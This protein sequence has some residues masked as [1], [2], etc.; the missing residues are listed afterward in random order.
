M[1]HLTHG[2]DCLSVNLRPYKA[3]T[4]KSGSKLLIKPS[5]KSVLTIRKNRH[6]DWL[7]AH[8][9]N[10]PAVIKRLTPILRGW[11]NYCRRGV[12]QVL[13][14][15]LAHGMLL[16]EQRYARRT[17][18]KK[19]WAWKHKQYWGRLT[20]ARKATWGFGANRPGRFLLKCSWFDMSRQALVPSL[21][22]PAAPRLKQD[23][24]ERI[25][26]HVKNLASRDQRLA[27]NQQ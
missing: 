25:K 19:T 4:S 22:S 12:A 21:Y 24:Q 15:K 23:W 9:A 20:L 3:Q 5:H 6:T 2:V 7:H 16:R 8:G 10:V 26:T 1:V 11:A 17:H 27:K 13:F 14:T 18:P